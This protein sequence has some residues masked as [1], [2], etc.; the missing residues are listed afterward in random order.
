MI[1]YWVIIYIL[2]A[3]FIC[4]FVLQ[5]DWEAKNKSRDNLA[6][7]SHTIGYSIGISF[8][9]TILLM[10]QA[11]ELMQRLITLPILSVF[12]ITCGLHSLTDYITSRIVRYYFDKG[13]THNGFVT[14]GGDQILHYIQLF[15]MYLWI[16][17][18]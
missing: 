1:Q 5:T 2:I 6:L 17:K 8:F 18:Y 15:G 3:H 16:I 4:D 10:I 13:D 9:F 11:P 14:I 12:C 7:F